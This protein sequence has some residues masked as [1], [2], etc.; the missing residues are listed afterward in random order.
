MRKILKPRIALVITDQETNAQIKAV[1]VDLLELRADLFHSHK[2]SCVVKD[3][4]RRRDLKIPL[5]L[6]VRNQKKE[7]AV[8]EFSDAHKQAILEVCM[9]LVDMVDI[10]LS[11]PLLRQTVALAHKL[12]KKVI[13]SYHNFDHTPQHKELLLK[14]ALSAG[15]DIVKIA[16]KAN[17]W[18]DVLRMIDFT[19][20]NR[21][22]NLITMS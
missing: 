18:D 5:L 17:T 1:G 8:K 22:H 14:K 6:T 11:S 4:K 16:A 10:E 13:V 3:I 19:R 20:R 15:A 21:K 7:G 9:P 2:P 12:R